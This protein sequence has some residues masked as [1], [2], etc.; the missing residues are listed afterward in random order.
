MAA[1]VEVPPG[2]ATT[3]PRFTEDGAH[4]TLADELASGVVARSHAA[5][6]TRVE[7]HQSVPHLMLY[8]R[9]ARRSTGD[10]PAGSPLHPTAGAS[11]TGCGMSWRRER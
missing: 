6:A 8:T 10:T 5:A 2:A 11:V 7:T 9:P 3:P 4:D 1:A